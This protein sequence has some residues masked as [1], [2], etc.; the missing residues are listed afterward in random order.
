MNWSLKARKAQGFA[1]DEEK[2]EEKVEGEEE[3]EDERKGG[4]G[5]G[6]RIPLVD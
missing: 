4:R 3:K 5:G 1:R 2:K 6:A